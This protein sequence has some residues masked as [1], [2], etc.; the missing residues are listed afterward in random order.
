[1][2]PTNRLVAVKAVIQKDGKILVLQQSSEKEVFGAN[3][4][5]PPGGIVEGDESLPEALVREVKE[6]AGLDI[7]VGRV[8]AVEEWTAN[9]RGTDFQFVG[10]FYECTVLDDAVTLQAEE[11]QGY[12]WVSL[13][14]I[15]GLGLVE[16]S[17]SVLRKAL[18]EA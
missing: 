5:H 16:P 2:Q 4:Y 11:A 1:M 9:I 3:K 6:E 14:E 10:I 15:D 17:L 8:V 7:S 13:D 18:K 12:A